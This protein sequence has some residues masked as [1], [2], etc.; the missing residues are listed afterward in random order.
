MNSLNKHRGIT[1]GGML[2][3]LALMSLAAYTAIR[4]S[5]AYMDYWLVQRALDNLAARP[6][7]QSLG[8]QNIRE[9]FAKQLRLNNITLA[10]RS[11]LLIE[12]VPGGVRLSATL[13]TKQPYIGRVSLC[14][15]FLAEASSAK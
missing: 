6:D 14:M 15:D 12:E 7:L 1:L 10:N 4:V 3:F 2:I 5:P 8:D 13:S 11:D 9:Q